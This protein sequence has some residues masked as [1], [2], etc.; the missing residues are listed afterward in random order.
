MSEISKSLEVFK[1][2][3]N[4]SLSFHEKMYGDDDDQTTHGKWVVWSEGGSI[5]DREW[6]V[7]AV[8]GTP[9]EAI[10]NIPKPLPTPPEE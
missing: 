10:Y 7:I 3:K 6:E 9:F 2:N 8:G 1:A 4:Y 5:N